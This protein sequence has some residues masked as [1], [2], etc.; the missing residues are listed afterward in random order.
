MKRKIGILILAFVMLFTSLS[1][2]EGNNAEA[3][4]KKGSTVT[5]KGQKYIYQGRF[6][7]YFPLKYCRLVDKKAKK[8]QSFTNFVGGT[9]GFASLARKSGYGGALASSLYI[10]C[11]LLIWGSKTI[12]RF[13]KQLLEKEPEY[14][15]VMI[16]M[17]LKL[18]QIMV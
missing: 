10:V 4:P 16:Y 15:L 9:S 1:F 8:F 12:L 17:F 14:L 6:N 7:H 3:A 11:I 13:I 2:I 5:I 18:D